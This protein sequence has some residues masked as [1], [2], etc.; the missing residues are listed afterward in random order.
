[1]ASRAFSFSIPRPYD[2]A[3]TMYS[4]G[5]PQRDI[6]DDLT[7]K[8]GTATSGGGETVTDIIQYNFGTGAATSV[9]IKFDRGFARQ[10]ENRVLIASFGDGYEQ[11]V[12][13]GINPKVETFNMNLANRRLEEIALISSFVDTTSPGHF[14]ITLELETIKVVCDTYSVNIGHDAVQSISMQ[15][16]RVY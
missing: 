6:F 2:P 1:M 3:V 11:R 13:D 14:N 15:L 12:R 9:E 10:T 7:A 5:T 16:R 4:I 8:Y